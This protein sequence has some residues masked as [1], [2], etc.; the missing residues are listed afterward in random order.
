[1]FFINII[2]GL[3]FLIY[4]KFFSNF[5]LFGISSVKLS[6][7]K[8]SFLSSSKYWCIELLTPMNL[9]TY[10]NNKPKI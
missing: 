8:I 1:M 3:K 2:N 9:S 10:N 4:L 6:N 7:F 5:F